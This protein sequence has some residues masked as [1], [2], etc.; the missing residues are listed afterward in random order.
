MSVYNMQFQEQF[1]DAATRDVPAHYLP[2]T[3]VHHVCLAGS[4]PLSLAI[5]KSYHMKRQ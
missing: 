4:L 2:Y 3:A 1:E 5:L